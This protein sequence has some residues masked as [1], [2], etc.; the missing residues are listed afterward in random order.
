MGNDI[1]FY[2]THTVRHG[3]AA[4]ALRIKINKHQIIM[5]HIPFSSL[6]IRLQAAS[7]FV[8]ISAACQVATGDNWGMRKDLPK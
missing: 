2:D 8:Q 7:C 6:L 3:Y 1:E 5:K 4:A